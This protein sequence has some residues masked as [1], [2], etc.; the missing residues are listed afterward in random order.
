MKIMEGTKFP[1]AKKIKVEFL[2]VIYVKP[3]NDTRS[4]YCTLARC[5][6]AAGI[7]LT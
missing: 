3:C 5:V 7:S 2:N 4:G 6:L 1:L